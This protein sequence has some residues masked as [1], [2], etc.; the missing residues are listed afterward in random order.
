MIKFPLANPKPDF[1]NLAAIL[2]G[3]KEPDKV[4]FVEMLIDEEIKKILIEEYFEEKNFPPTVTFGGSSESVPGVKSYSQNKENSEKYYKQLINFYYR[5][6]YSVLADYE[7]LVNFQS[8]N[9]VGRVGKD[10]YTSD[11]ARSERHWAQEGKGLIRTW[12]DFEKFPWKKVNR[13]KYAKNSLSFDAFS[14]NWIIMVAFRVIAVFA[15]VFYFLPKRTT[16]QIRHFNQ[17]VFVYL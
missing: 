13:W 17:P 9:T 10:P 8:F 4:P 5:M 12:E 6:G 16:F 14:S 15:V 3:K 2:A 7:F 1:N 11:Y